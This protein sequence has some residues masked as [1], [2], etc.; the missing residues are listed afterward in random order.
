M[1]GEMSLDC[2]LGGKVGYTLGEIMY[3]SL[4]V[5]NFQGMN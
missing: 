3:F 5:L 4:I 1:T 2:G